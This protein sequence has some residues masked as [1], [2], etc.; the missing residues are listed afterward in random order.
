MIFSVLYHSIEN[1]KEKGGCQIF[2]I[3]NVSY[4]KYSF[5]NIDDVTV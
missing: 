5:S 3:Q 4:A 2:N 1:Q